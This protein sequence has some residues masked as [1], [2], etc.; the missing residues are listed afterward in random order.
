MAM[1]VFSY[2]EPTSGLYLP[3]NPRPGREDVEYY[4]SEAEGLL[5]CHKCRYL[6]TGRGEPL[7]RLCGCSLS[8]VVQDGFELVT[9]KFKQ[10]WVPSIFVLIP[11]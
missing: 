8:P 4:Q 11:A 5:E 6:C 9:Q 10:N 1:Y 3:S 2:S 7:G